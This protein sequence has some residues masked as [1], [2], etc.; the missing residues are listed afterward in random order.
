MA[1]VAVGAMALVCIRCKHETSTAQVA[2]SAIYLPAPKT[3]GTMSLEEAIAKRRSIRDFSGEG[4]TTEQVS[5]LAWAA[6]GITD[7]K[8]LL[9]A[10][11]SAG[12]TYPLDLYLVTSEGIFRYLP[13]EHALAPVAQG[14]MRSQ[15]GSGRGAAA[16]A[17][18]DVVIVA[19][20]E[21]IRKR[22]GDRAERYACLEAGHV[23]QNL[24]LQATALGLGGVPMGGI[25]GEQV[26][27]VLT[28]PAGQDPLYVIPIGHP[29]K[30]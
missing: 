26:A 13:V 25:Q 30:Q 9:R 22:F 11:P 29:V 4:L 12:A 1:L 21:R 8:R 18:L 7:A 27:G 24:L 2:V 14:D 10:A 17:P 20:Y 5:Q 16:K 3:E 6:Q 19:D 23:A 28:L 15:L